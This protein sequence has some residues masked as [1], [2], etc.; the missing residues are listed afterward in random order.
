MKTKI[1]F[2]ILL[3]G[4]FVTEGCNISGDGSTYTLY[5]SSVMADMPRIHVATFDAQDGE[6]YNRENCQIAAD[7][8]LAQPGVIVKYWC[9]KGLFRK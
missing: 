9:E 5:R 8:F 7:L 6:K 1:K 3:A 4:I 2:F